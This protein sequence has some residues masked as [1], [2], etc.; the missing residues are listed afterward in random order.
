[1]SQPFSIPW[2]EAETIEAA[3]EIQDSRDK[4]MTIANLF[5]PQQFLGERLSLPRIINNPQRVRHTTAGGKAMPVKREQIQLIEYDTSWIKLF[6][7]ITTD[8]KNKFYDAM[9]PVSP[10]GGMEKFRTLRMLQADEIVNRIASRFRKNYAI[11]RRALCSG[12]L[13]GSYSYRVG[14]AAAD[15]TVSLG[16]TALTA[17]AVDWD[18]KAATISTDIGDAYREFVDS[19]EEALEPTHLV[20]N[21]DQIRDYF[22]INDEFKAL[23]AESPRMSEWFMGLGTGNYLD[24]MGRVKDPLWGLIWIPAQGKTRSITGSLGD[25]FPTDTLTLMRLGDDGC[26]PTWFQKFDREQQPDINPRI[27]VKAPQDGDDVKN[28]KVVFFSNGLPGFKRPDLVQTLK[29]VAS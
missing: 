22:L 2:L 12:A 14:D 26:Q 20:Y 5:P 29:V 7:E 18:N 27:E 15:M 24:L 23:M 19:N 13:Q 3:I 6:D 9:A 17:P 16:L 1:M 25:M 21:P 10:N 4:T 11:E 8:D 28:H